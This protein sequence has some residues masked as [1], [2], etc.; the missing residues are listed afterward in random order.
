MRAFPGARIVLAATHVGEPTRDG[1]IVEVR[2]EDGGP[3]YVVEWSDGHTGLLFPGPGSVLHVSE[4]HEDGGR[5][6]AGTAE[7]G[8]TQP[9]AGDGSP[10]PASQPAATGPGQPGHVREWTVRISIYESGDDT[11][12]QAVLLGDSP[13]HLQAAGDSHRSPDDPVVPE[14][15]DEVAAGRALRHLAER[16][17]VTADDDIAAVTGEDAHVRRS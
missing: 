7:A 5:A 10:A 2:G 13:Q 1:R 14:I 12:A 16:L 15:G 8:M 6:D 4:K 11:H 3:P 17:L 9:V